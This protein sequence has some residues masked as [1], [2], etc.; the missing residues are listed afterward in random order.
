VKLPFF[1]LSFSSGTGIW[2]EVLAL[3]SQSLNHLSHTPSPFLFSYSLDESTCFCLGLALD[4]DLPTYTSCVTDIADLLHYTQLIFWEGVLLTFFPG[5]PQTV[6][7]LISTYQEVQIIS[8]YHY[9]WPKHIILEFWWHFN[10]C[11]SLEG[12]FINIFGI[13]KKFIYF[14]L[15]ILHL[16]M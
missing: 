11:N 10:I 16:G 9:T 7:L 14:I 4:H 5:W 12:Y 1:L 3:V 13:I 2:T 6:I 15:I 8:M